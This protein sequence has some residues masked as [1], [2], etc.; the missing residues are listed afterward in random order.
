MIINL[1]LK[2]FEIRNLNEINALNK[3]IIN[4]IF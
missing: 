4:I 1:Y 3:N 2:N